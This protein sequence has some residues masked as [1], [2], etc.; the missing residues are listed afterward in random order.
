[1]NEIDLQDILD[2]DTRWYYKLDIMIEMFNVFSGMAAFGWFTIGM[3]VWEPLA[4]MGLYFVPKT[5]PQFRRGLYLQRLSRYENAVD[6]EAAE[7]A[8]IC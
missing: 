1:M 8:R 7:I 2:D 5:M 6:S 3:K 4:D